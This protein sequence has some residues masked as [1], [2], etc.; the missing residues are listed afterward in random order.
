MEINTRRVVELA[1]EIGEA[2]VSAQSL[3]CEERAFTVCK[4]VYDRGRSEQA[5]R[6][7]Q[8]KVL[9]L[10]LER[11]GALREELGSGR[12]S[13]ALYAQLGD[14]LRSDRFQ[15]FVLSD[16]FRELVRGA[17]ER[18]W[19]LSAR[20]RLHWQ[21]ESFHVVDHDNG[22]QL[23]PADTLSGGETFMT[24]LA[25]A[26]ELSEQVQRMSGAAKLCSLFIDE[27]FGT[28]D[29]ESL[30]AAAEAIENLPTAGRMVGIITHIEELSRRLPACITVEKHASAIGIEIKAN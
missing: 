24:A 30:N 12:R 2:E 5:R 14:D 6:G 29:P 3:R 20:Y 15:A 22:R 21:D 19:E 26:L 27:G 8:I 4:E 17:S 16:T 1:G 10:R 13:H 7:E 18:L 11:A 28:L 23:R 25:L 9:E